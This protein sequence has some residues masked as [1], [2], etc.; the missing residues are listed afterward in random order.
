MTKK[1]FSLNR[2]DSELI[3][4]GLSKTRTKSYGANE[5]VTSNDSMRFE[6]TTAIW[7]LIYHP[8]KFLT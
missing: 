1:S 8:S 3:K 7:R 2:N 6:L 4:I 5:I